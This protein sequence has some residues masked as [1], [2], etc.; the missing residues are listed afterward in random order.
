MYEKGAEVVRLYETL[1]GR[2]G[3]RKGMDLY[4]ERHDGQAVTCDD[5]LAAMADA[6]DA[7]LSS[8]AR[9][10]STP[11]TPTVTVQGVYDS[12]ARTYTVTA[13]Q[14]V[15]KSPDAAPLLVP[16]ATALL[17]AD[18]KE[19]PLRVDGQD[20]GTSTVWASRQARVVG[21]CYCVHLQSATPLLGVA[22]GAVVAGVGV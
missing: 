18:G 3:F 20:L 8:F 7:D 10:Y 4:F 17:A 13:S 16:I 14:C 19:L 12:A 11:G 21:T 5:F 2:D 6:N 9:W 1:L 15:G 22:A